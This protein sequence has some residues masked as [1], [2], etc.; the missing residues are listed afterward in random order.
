MTFFN[1]K[2]GPVKNLRFDSF[3]FLC[4]PKKNNN[5]HYLFIMASYWRLVKTPKGYRWFDGKTYKLRKPVEG[6]HKEGP[7]APGVSAE[8]AA[9]MQRKIRQRNFEKEQTKTRNRRAAGR[10]LVS[11]KGAELKQ[12]VEDLGT[13]LKEGLERIR[14]AAQD[15]WEKE[16]YRQGYKL[17]KVQ[18]GLNA[19]QE[20]LMQSPTDKM[21][22]YQRQTTQHTG[23]LGPTIYDL[24]PSNPALKSQIQTH[25]TTYVVNGVTYDSA[26]NQPVQPSQPVKTGGQVAIDELR[27]QV[28]AKQAGSSTR[29]TY[30]VA[31]VTYDTATGASIPQ[32]AQ[33]QQ[34]Q[35]YQPQEQQSTYQRRSSVSDSLTR[36]SEPPT[37]APSY[38]PSYQRR[39]S[40]PPTSAPQYQP[41]QSSQPAQPA[42]PAP[43]VDT[44]KADFNR[45]YDEARQTMSQEELENFG[46]QLHQ[47]YFSK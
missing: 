16:Q 1:G 6:K 43:Q 23:Q 35:T 34:T 40:E 22:A 11:K 28:Q 41:S 32:A 8:D 3:S 7:L 14:D 44:R 20:F 13:G 21:K 18:R 12:G 25:Q 2:G 17:R 42:Q 47:E 9:E 29:K 31:G 19:A 46:M 26:T 38:Q 27:R 5:Y 10:R 15:R 36:H 24:M 37:S 30:T 45:R 39:S 33:P 4:Q